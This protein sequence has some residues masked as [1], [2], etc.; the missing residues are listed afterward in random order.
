MISLLFLITWMAFVAIMTLSAWSVGLWAAALA[1]VLSLP[2]G[3]G[4]TIA[5]FALWLH[6]Y[7]A[8]RP[9]MEREAIRHHRFLDGFL[10]LAIRIL[11]FKVHASGLTNIPQDTSFVFVANHQSNYDTLVHKV[12]LPN[13][14]VFIAKEAIFKWIII[15]PIARLMGHIPMHRAQD[16]E[17]AKAMIE[18]INVVNSGI[19]VGIY[20]EG[21]RSKQNSM[22]PFKPGALKLAIKPGAPVLVGVIYNT[23]YAWKNWP[24]KKQHIYV[25][26]YPLID[27]ET[28]TSMTSSA[29]SDHIRSLIQDKLDEFIQRG[30]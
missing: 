9:G 12:L 18:G 21:T 15:G 23:I 25:H 10:V 6:M 4:I 26:Y 8:S 27:A 14:L 11:R 29:L 20:P 7:G 30:V 24:F 17:A 2:L 3:F 19:S 28:V 13:P 16:R 5:I 1:F 22:L